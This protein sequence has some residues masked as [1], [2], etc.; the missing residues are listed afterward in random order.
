MQEIIKTIKKSVKIISK[1]ILKPETGYST[2]QNATGDLQLK[3][4]IRCD[5]L[6][7]ANLSKC[8]NIKAIISEEKENPFLL[9]EDAEYIVAYDPLD[10]SSVFESNFT[11]GSI[12][13]IYKQT[14]EPKNLKCA[15]YSIYGAKTQIII[16]EN[17]PKLYTLIDDDFV[18]EKDLMLNEKG[19]L[20]SPGGTYKNHTSKHKDFI[21]QLFE[22]G[23]RL[24][25]SG[26]MVADLHQ[27]LV[28]GGGIFSYPATSD[29]PNGKLRALF[30]VYP[31]AYIF[32]NANGYTDDGNGNDL[33]SL[34]FPMIHATTPC[35]FG[36]KYEIEKLKSIM[37]D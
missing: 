15:I 25:Y 35:Y 18:Y 31:F 9:Y 1:D 11:V 24:R 5:D 10:G 27:I 23:Y 14:A 21:N 22:E 13:A 33:L 29:A 26:A 37:K 36:S 30:E 19:K 34:K 32:K 12:F 20:N 17:T 4:D 6:I 28:K 7:A 3:Q 8:G 16:C 2:S